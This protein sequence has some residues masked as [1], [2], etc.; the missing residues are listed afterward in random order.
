MTVRIQ[1]KYGKILLYYFYRS[2]QSNLV[3]G[4]LKDNLSIILDSLKIKKKE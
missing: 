3:K 4:M 1:L 2:G